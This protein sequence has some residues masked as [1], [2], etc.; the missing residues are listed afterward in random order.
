M[1]GLALLL[2]V[3]ITGCDLLSS[4]QQANNQGEN[5]G[6]VKLGYVQWAS[7]EASIHIV[8]EVIERMGYDVQVSSLETGAKYQ[9]TAQGQ[10][11]AF[12]S[13][14]LPDT[15]KF[16]WE[17]FEDRLVELND[18]YESAEIGLV[19]PSYVDIDSI[20]EMKDY[21]DKFDGRIV[22]IDPGAAQMILIEEDVMPNYDLE[23]W[24]LQ[25]SSGP[26]M[27]AELA[28]A[29]DNEEWIAVTGW[30]P[31]WKWSKWDL[32]FLEDPDL[33]MGTGEYIKSMGRPDIREDL[34]EVAG[35]LENYQVTTEELGS[36]MLM[37]QDG[38]DPEEAAKEFVDNNLDLVRNWLP[39]GI[40]I[41]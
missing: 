35:F 19:V 40:D 36:V 18:N 20:K 11:D 23:D 1:V 6:E 32:K 15:D 14:W 5:K 25:A 27:T 12:V 3:T 22:G 2:L 34:P 30:K 39:E 21:E 41:D 13:S 24:G 4:P 26:A 37:I 9:S 31:H 33:T 16:Y 7:A 28:R 8:Q 29:I 17:Q 10:L 38:M